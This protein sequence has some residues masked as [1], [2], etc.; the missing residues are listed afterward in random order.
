[1]FDQR[2]PTK[3]GYPDIED[4]VL[5]YIASEIDRATDVTAH[6]K[7]LIMSRSKKQTSKQQRKADNKTVLS[8]DDKAFDHWREV[9]H[10]FEYIDR[11][12]SILDKFTRTLKYYNQHKVVLDQLKQDTLLTRV[13][14]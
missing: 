10:M 6:E 9:R 7:H 8:D 13:V 14:A 2:E 3:E 11:L 1:V 5:R 4:D 12:L